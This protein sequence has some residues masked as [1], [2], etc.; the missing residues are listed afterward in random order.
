LCSIELLIALVSVVKS[1]FKFSLMCSGV[2]MTIWTHSAISTSND[3]EINLL[4]HVFKGVEVG[5]KYSDIIPDKMLN[6][7]FPLK[8]YVPV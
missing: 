6:C 3:H 2:I 5:G 1:V 4:A 7:N 8:F